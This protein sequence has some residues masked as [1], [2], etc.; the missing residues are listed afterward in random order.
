MKIERL[1]QSVAHPVDISG[2]PDGSYYLSISNKEFL[3]VERIVKMSE[4]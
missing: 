1:F 2:L 4:R 3:K